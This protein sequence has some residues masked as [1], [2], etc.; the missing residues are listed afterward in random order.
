MC[1]AMDP[2]GQVDTKIVIGLMAAGGGLD[3]SEKLLE[4]GC[5][6]GRTL[7]SGTPWGVLVVS[8][9]SSRALRSTASPER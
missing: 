3:P 7:I 5:E 8:Y 2:T 4:I 9:D 1:N 6:A